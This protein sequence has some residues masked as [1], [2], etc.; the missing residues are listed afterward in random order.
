MAT[1]A[2]KCCHCSALLGQEQ[3]AVYVGSEVLWVCSLA[4]RVAVHARQGDKEQC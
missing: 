4:C 2:Q 3:Y 1:T